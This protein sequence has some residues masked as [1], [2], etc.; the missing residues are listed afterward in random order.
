MNIANKTILILIA[1]ALVPLALAAAFMYTTGNECFR[2][3]TYQSS[4]LLFS[5]MVALA[6]I[7]FGL[8][9]AKALTDPLRLLAAAVADFA[10]HPDQ[11]LSA[12]VIAPDG[13][14]EVGALRDEFHIMSEKIRHYHEDLEDE[15]KKRTAELEAFSYSV[16]HDLRAPL[17]AMDGFVKM[18]DEDYGKDFDE[19]G[20]R[21]IAVIQTNA[22]QMGKL[23]DDL[24]SFSRLGRQDV[25][26]TRISMKPLVQ[27]VYIEMQR[28]DPGHV[29]DI[30]ITEMPDA[31]AD[32]NMI[33]LVW[34]NLLSNAMKFSH[35]RE[36]AHIEIGGTEEADTG[37]VSYFVKDNG[38]G[39]DMKYVDKLFNV[40]QRLHP[41][42]EFE[43]TGIGLANVRRIVERHG[44]SVRARGEVDKGATFYFTLPSPKE[45][46]MSEY[47]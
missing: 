46:D 33:R 23:I 8:L 18:L 7:F 43:G 29:T 19:E 25:T 2:E 15:V 47:D 39:F 20:K 1:F 37:T 10:A 13:H 44:G 16:S 9:A 11:S 26:K 14:D 12:P 3:Q 30:T 41:A 34:T 35:M 22:K 28:S 32:P 45:A 24:L 4:F 5:F 21:I 27:S 31:F 38:V 42:S 40:F 17:R 36:K 6:S